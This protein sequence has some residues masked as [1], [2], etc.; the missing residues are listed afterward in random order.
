MQPC[1]D[2][3]T[4]S[5]EVTTTVGTITVT[6][7]HRYTFQKGLYGFT[8]NHVYAL[9]PM[10]NMAPEL[11]YRVLHALDG[12]N[13]TFILKRV[14]VGE[15]REAPGYVAKIDALLNAQGE[16]DALMLSMMVII[17][18]DAPPGSRVHLHTKAP[19]IF[20]TQTMTAR[21]VIIE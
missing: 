12:E 15:M 18:K 21:Q 1:H 20:N 2:L 13:A 6:P 5:Y 19:L 10:P 7:T 3:E 9:A 11:G 17:D 16:R 14:D 8:H 4:A